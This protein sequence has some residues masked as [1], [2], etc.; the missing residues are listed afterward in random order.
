MDYVDAMEELIN[1]DASI[2]ISY[3]NF[4][5][6]STFDQCMALLALNTKIKKQT[7][8]IAKLKSFKTKTIRC[9]STSSQIT[10]KLN[11]LLKEK[12]LTKQDLFLILNNLTI[13]YE[14]DC[15]K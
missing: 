1:K 14:E 10:D 6:L 3:R 4:R 5:S 11:N 8:K 15:E 9:T 7:D 13:H 12:K 2:G